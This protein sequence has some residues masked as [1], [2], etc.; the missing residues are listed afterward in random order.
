MKP[1]MGLSVFL[2]SICLCV[3]LSACLSSCLSVSLSINHQETKSQNQ[4]V[5]TVPVLDLPPYSLGPG[6]VK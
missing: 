6:Y 5:I 3:G 4:T 2:L 1:S